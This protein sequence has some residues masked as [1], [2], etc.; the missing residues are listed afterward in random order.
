[1]FVDIRT[2]NGGQERKSSEKMLLKLKLKMMDL[3]SI[4]DLLIKYIKNER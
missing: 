3:C 1:M 4:S 2:A